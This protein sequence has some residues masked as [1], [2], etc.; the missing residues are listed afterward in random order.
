[1]AS[2]PATAD[3]WDIS[4]TLLDLEVDRGEFDGASLV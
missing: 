1:M 2:A 4:T 3:L